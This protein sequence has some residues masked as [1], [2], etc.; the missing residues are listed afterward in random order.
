[1]A[2]VKV[3]EFP[4]ASLSITRLLEEMRQELIIPDMDDL[5]AEHK[6]TVKALREAGKVT[7]AGLKDLQDTEVE[8]LYATGDELISALRKAAK[9]VGEGDTKVARAHRKQAEAAFDQGLAALKDLTRHANGTSEAA[10]SILLERA[11]TGI[12]DLNTLKAK[13]KK[14]RSGEDDA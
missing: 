9:A 3:Q 4:F 5:V 12:A 1:M 11:R 2:K 7:E 10:L 13:Q 6:K 8:K 14:K